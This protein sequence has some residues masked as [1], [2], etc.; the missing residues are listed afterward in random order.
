[1]SSI[2]GA[3]DV[4][5]LSWRFKLGIVVFILAFALWLL[6]PLAVVMDFPGSTI[7]ALTGGLFITNK[8]LLLA[9][10]AIMGKAGFQQLKGL[11]FGYVGGLAPETVSPLRY[12]IGLV[13]FCLPL[14]S[15]FLEPYVDSIWPGLRPNLWQLQLLGDVMLIASFF[16]LGS[17]FWEK[18]RA[19]FIRTARVVDT[20]DAR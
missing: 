10:I 4:E 14:L 3:A 16:V 19:L 7:A 20:A 2:G 15:S 13:M 17:S 11:V 1:M 18:M 8:I 6:L 12:R 5:T 9:V